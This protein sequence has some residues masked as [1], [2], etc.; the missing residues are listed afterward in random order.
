MYREWLEQVQ[1]SEHDVG[2]L[3]KLFPR[4]LE[5]FKAPIL[6]PVV[7]ELGYLQ[8]LQS[9]HLYSEMMRIARTVYMCT[10]YSEY[11]VQ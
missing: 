3:E 9:L 10:V 6:Q 2:E 11:S 1:L 4:Q 5:D 7:L 8:L